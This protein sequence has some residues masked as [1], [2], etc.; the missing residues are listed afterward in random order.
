MNWLFFTLISVLFVSIAVIFQRALMRDEKSNPYYYTTFFQFSIAILTVPIAIVHGFQ[1]PPVTISL[2]FFPVAA[3]L[4]GGASVF[5]FKALKFAEASE[6]TIVSSIR[7]I[8]TILA[9]IFF[10]HERFTSFNALGALFVLVSIFLVTNLKK[11]LKFNKGV[12]YALITA[13]FSG[14][15]IVADGFN[16]KNYDVIS[17]TTIINFLIFFILFAIFP[18]VL[19]HWKSFIKINF[20]KNMVP[21]TIF[22]TIQGI[23]YLIALANGG[24]VSQVGTIRQASVITTVILAVLFLKEKDFFLR[25]LIAAILVTIGVILLS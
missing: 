3:I 6:V 1:F 10:L 4:W 11:G 20:L 23:A 13:V 16:V 14:L 17:Y 19:Q 12:V 5:F 7:I 22:S 24:N 2:V 25:K 18:T 8:I 21:I 9:S 15:A